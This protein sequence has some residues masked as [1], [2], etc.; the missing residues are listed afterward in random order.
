MYKSKEQLEEEEEA[1]RLEAEIQAMAQKGV[2]DAKNALS[3]QNMR[4]NKRGGGLKS[5]MTVKSKDSK[6][7]SSGRSILNKSKTE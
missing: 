5:M 1:A 2:A 3:A 6:K 4:K 7:T